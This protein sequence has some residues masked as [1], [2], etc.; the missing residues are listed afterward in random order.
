MK[1]ITDFEAITISGG[2]KD[3]N[4]HNKNKKKKPTVQIDSQDSFDKPVEM[5]EISSIT[6]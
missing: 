2:C 4:C 6:E 1:N 3:P 5:T